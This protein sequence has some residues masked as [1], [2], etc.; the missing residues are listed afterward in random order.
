MRLYFAYGSNMWDAQMAR[1]CPQSRKIGG[2][3]LS[4]YRW[5]ISTRGYANVVLSPVD[6]VEGVL[7]EIAK[8]DEQALDAFE[9]VGSGPYVKRDLPVLCDGRMALALVYVD[10]VSA[11]GTPKVEYIHR[12]NSGLRDARLSEKYVAGYIRKYIPTESNTQ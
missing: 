3:L 4:G 7:F 10:P 12:I 11:E 5:M 6:K 2:G 8:S 1:R 9:G